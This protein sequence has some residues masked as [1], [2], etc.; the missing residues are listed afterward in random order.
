MEKTIG[1]VIIRMIDVDSADKNKMQEIADAYEKKKVDIIEFVFH[2]LQERYSEL[3]ADGLEEALGIPV[4]DIDADQVLYYKQ[5]I[6]AEHVFSFEYI[7]MFD[8]CAYFSING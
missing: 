8:K 5:T 2:S 6:D 1:N 4:I 3:K 7:G